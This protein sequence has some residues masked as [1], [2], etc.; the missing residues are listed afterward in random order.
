[1]SETPSATGRWIRTTD[2]LRDALVDLPAGPL[3]LDVE[4]DSFH[5]YPEKVCLVQ[6]SVGSCDWLLDPL[7]ELDLTALSGLTEDRG[8]RKILHGADYDVRLLRRDFGLR[9]EGLFDTMIAARLIGERKFGLAALLERYV[10]VELDKRYQRADWSQRPLPPEMEAYAVLDTR[11][12]AEL[13]QHLESELSRL[14]RSSWAAEEF[15]RI[16]EVRWNSRNDDP[17]SYRRVKGAGRLAPRALAVVRELHALRERVAVERDRPPFMILR[18]ELLVALALSAVSPDHSDAPR[19]PRPWQRA[20]AATELREAL[21]RGMAVPEA[22]LPERRQGRKRP[23]PRL[24]AGVR[25][26]QSRRD[27]LAAKLDL[28]PS[29]VASRAVLEQVQVRLAADEDPRQAPDLRSW[30]AELLLD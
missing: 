30:Q 3:A 27:E 19:L 22:E 25:K 28:E 21:A 23:D 9:L 18:D 14:G 13:A 11:H 20:R 1:M 29:V 15:R 8:R 2:E 6:L 4:A 26:L 7:A 5:H 17:E 10:G 16:E 24:E 12:L